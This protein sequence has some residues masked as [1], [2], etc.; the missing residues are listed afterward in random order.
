MS[1][2]AAGYDDRAKP[3]D[4]DITYKGRVIT[5]HDLIGTGHNLDGF[6]I[7]KRLF[8]RPD[9]DMTRLLGFIAAGS[10]VYDVGAYIGTFA[11]PMALEGMRV[12]AFEGSPDNYARALR[13]CGPFAGITVHLAAVSDRKETVITKFND[14]T[15]LPPEPRRITYVVLDDFMAEEGLEPPGL[16]KLDIE[17]METVALHGMRKL[18]ETTRPVWQIGYHV[19]L[20]VKYDGYP[21]FR[22]VADGGFDFATFRRLGYRVYDERN[23]EVPG[24]TGWG[25][26]LCVPEEWTPPSR[27][28]SPAS[29]PE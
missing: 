9:H 23:C 8:A 10:V 14:C 18:L 25:D 29:E 11:I 5:F 12:H 2:V 17:G 3:M 6:V 22:S 19:G 1:R 13:N 16:V 20:D 24:F 15:A 21:G 26:Y 27:S 7:R 28:A 4:A